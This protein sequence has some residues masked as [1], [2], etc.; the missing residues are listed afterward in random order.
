MIPTFYIMAHAVDFS[1]KTSRTALSFFTPSILFLPSQNSFRSIKRYRR[2]MSPQ[3]FSSR[4]NRMVKRPLR[5]WWKAKQLLPR[6]ESRSFLPFYFP[7]TFSFLI[8]H[9]SSSSWFSNTNT[10]PAHSIQQLNTFHSAVEHCSGFPSLL[11]Q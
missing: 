11:V 2:E 7:S 1:I 6:E 9:V 8:V 4:R 5:G 10:T 3:P